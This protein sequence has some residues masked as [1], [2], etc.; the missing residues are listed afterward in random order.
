LGQRRQVL[1]AEVSLCSS[2]RKIRGNDKGK[3]GA[4]VRKLSKSSTHKIG[5]ERPE[6]GSANSKREKKSSLFAGTYQVTKSDVFRK[7]QRPRRKETGGGCH[8]G[9]TILPHTLPGFKTGVQQEKNLERGIGGL[10]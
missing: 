5:G 4:K 7:L 9:L 10:Y 8:P 3:K 2:E 6:S 1:T